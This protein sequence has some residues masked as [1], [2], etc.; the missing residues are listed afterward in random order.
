MPIRFV[1]RGMFFLFL[2]L[3]SGLGVVCGSEQQDGR[4]RVSGVVRDCV[5][6]SG[7]G[8]SQV[9]YR[10]GHGG[11][12][13]GTSCDSA[14]R[15][16]FQVDGVEVGDTLRVEFLSL[17]YEGRDTVIVL[18]V[19]QGAVDLSVCLVAEV[20]E[21][22]EA[23]VSAAGRR[24]GATVQRLDLKGW[25]GV[26]SSLG[27][28]IEALVKSL[29]GVSSRNELSSQYSVRGGSFDENLVYIDGVEVYR[30][31]LVRSGH[32][33]GLSI[34]NPDMVSGVDFSAGGF[35]SSYGD[36]LSSV[37]DIHYR[38]PARVGGGLHLSLLENR[39]YVEAG[40]DKF[41][42]GALLGVRYKNT[43]LLLR[44]TDA[45]GEYRPHFFDVQ[46]KVVCR[47]GRGWE[48]GL[49]GFYL[50]NGYHFIPR[51]RETQV[52][53]ILGDMRS[54]VV[55]Y[56]GQE[57]DRY[58]TVLGS[59][60]LIWRPDRAWEARLLLPVTLLRERERYDLLG[61]YWLAEV[62]T[63]DEARAVNDSAAN[64]GIG[65]GFD[66]ADNG[67]GC[68]DFSPQLTLEY[69]FGR[70][71]ILGGAGY[72]FRTFTHRVREWSLQDSAGY[73]LPYAGLGEVFLYRS[74]LGMD[75]LSDHKAWGY[76]QA[77]VDFPLSWGLLTWVVGCRVSGVAHLGGVEVSP[78]TSL[79]LLPEG[80]PSLRVYLAGGA[81]HQYVHYREMMDRRGALHPLGARP[82]RS[83][84]GVVG[85]RYSFAIGWRPFSLQVEGYYKYLD[86][87]IPYTVDNLRLQYEGE[88]ASRGRVLGI[89]A[90]LNGELV[91]GAQSWVSV[92][93]M[94]G[95]QW[96]YRTLG[97]GVAIPGLGE[98]FPLPQDQ[99]FSG[100]LHLRDYLPYLPSFQV[101]L[102]VHYST[103]IPFTPPHVPY[104]SYAR[105]PSY[106]RI[107]IGFTKVFKDYRHCDRWLESR[108]DWLR[109]WSVSFE[110]L[111]LFDF[112][113]VASYMWVRVPGP[114]GGVSELAVPNYLTA[115]C[116]NVVMRMQL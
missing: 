25:G 31:S 5:S 64:V 95:E 8:F 33:E 96:F 43:G 61:E 110:V 19:G 53:S 113:N 54:L 91:P 14:G 100:S 75:T 82:Q 30:P 103:G 4:L 7:L 9:G 87:L 59:V 28:G 17:G 47:L 72:R 22:G 107:D 21:I 66:H 81:Y 84:H 49:S 44:T 106:K 101:N 38:R 62:G 1:N 108:S 58:E 46:G 116:F 88:N 76:L 29:G 50:Q 94:G 67:Y 37:L 99:V 56:E 90:R 36:R 98:R 41:P 60:D 65:G 6:G 3:F 39:L 11:G 86:R 35:P 89:E 32:Q 12:L 104:G 93:V 55:Y 20:V 70:G 40:D 2:L 73:T 77:E 26:T 102:S 34:I 57:R 80:V 68:V 69:R 48:L 18:G 78:R 15:F 79:S 27:G 16:D 85:L 115:R 51:R 23:W 112:D 74:R 83:L 24:G 52:G 10:V 97:E 92:S 71:R 45:E 63:P 111:N 114:S 13:L 109:E 105:M 42:V